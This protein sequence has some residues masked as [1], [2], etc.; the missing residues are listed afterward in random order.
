MRSETHLTR[1]TQ[2][3]VGKVS[4]E[5]YIFFPRGLGDLLLEPGDEVIIVARE[6]NHADCCDYR[7]GKKDTIFERVRTRVVS[8]IAENR[9][10]GKGGEDY[11]EV[12]NAVKEAMGSKR[13]VKEV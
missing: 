4:L 7:C 2:V 9:F 8:M 10:T 3:R 5:S 12:L 6:G 1:K 11:E 13:K